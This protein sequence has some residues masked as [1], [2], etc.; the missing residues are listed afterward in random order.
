MN[1]SLKMLIQCSFSR[2]EQESPPCKVTRNDDTVEVGMLDSNEEHAATM[3]CEELMSNDAA[4][5]LPCVI[6]PSSSQLVS[7][8]KQHPCQP[9]QGISFNHAI[10]Y[11]RLSLQ[12]DQVPRKWVS[13]SQE[14]DSLICFICL[15]FCKS[16][17]VPFS[18]SVLD[19]KHVYT[20]LKEHENSNMHTSAV[21]A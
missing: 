7:F 1:R 6:R 12:G 8:L 19:R 16:V 17:E 18:V 10:T 4:S 15:A 2:E 11:N 14:H 21:E 20:R 5:T 9:T 3:A 13:Y